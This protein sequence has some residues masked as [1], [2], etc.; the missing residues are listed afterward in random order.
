V[1]GCD[2]DISQQL[3]DLFAE[4][5][6][7]VVGQQTKARAVGQKYALPT[8]GAEAENQTWDMTVPATDAAREWDGYG[9][10][11]KPAVE[12]IVMARKPMD[13][14][15]AENVVKWGTGALNID[16]CRVAGETTPIN[17]LETWS[18]FGQA[19]RPEYVAE[20]NKGRWPAQLVHDGSED[21]LAVFPQTASGKD[22]V[23]RASSK[24]RD[25]NTG[26]AFGAES[27]PEG[28]PM[29][30]YGDAG[31]AA[32]FFQCCPPDD[33]ELELSQARRLVYA[34]KTSP[35]ERHFGCETN[36]H[37]TVKPVLVTPP[38]GRILDPFMGSGSTGIAARLEGFSFLG[39]EQD[40]QWVEVAQARLAAWAVRPK[41]PEPVSRTV[42]DRQLDLGFE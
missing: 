9:T 7:E 18:G 22:T 2:E 21:V 38:N 17:R 1:L 20:V 31:S 26:A 15:V 33:D 12:I 14:T 13:G 34:A 16:D 35:A 10:A 6:R 23:M 11:L 8:M 19:E 5:E 39:I 36:R 32:R 30:F 28:T 24:D 27:R 37:A 42:D 40:P 25:G 4:A 29:I 3:D 41:G